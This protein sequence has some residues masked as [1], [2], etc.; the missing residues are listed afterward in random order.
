MNNFLP[1]KIILVFVFMTFFNDLPAQV[2]IG[3]ELISL[4]NFLQ[5]QYEKTKIEGCQIVSIDGNDLLTVTVSVKKDT[6]NKEIVS[7]RKALR[8]CG[9]YLYGVKTISIMYI[10]YKKIDDP[11]YVPEDKLFTTSTS[12]VKQLSPM[13]SFDYG[14]KSIFVY[15][16]QYNPKQ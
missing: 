15:Y 12:V 8:S 6:K 11:D 2:P 16:T 10:D 4:S 13:K 3:A 5:R 7:N 1:T 14:D 9:E